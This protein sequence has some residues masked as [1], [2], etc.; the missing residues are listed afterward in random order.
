[1]EPFALMLTGPYDSV[2]HSLPVRIILSEFLL[3]SLAYLSSPPL[4]GLPLLSSFSYTHRHSSLLSTRIQK[5][6]FVEIRE[7]R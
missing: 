3:K 4:S 2:L 5:N 1:M 7:G 6:V